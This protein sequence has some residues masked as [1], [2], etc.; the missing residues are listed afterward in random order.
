MIT[1]KNYIGNQL[2]AK[3]TTTHKT[4]NPKLNTENPTPFFQATLEEVN[5]AVK[6]ADS[7]FKVYRNI[8]GKQRAAFLNAIADEILALDS[9]LTDMYCQNLDYQK[10]EHK[11]KEEEPL[12]N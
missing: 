10:E 8:S 12:V 4:V 11:E 9:E 5:E 2:S 7:A 6:L 1:G 3:G